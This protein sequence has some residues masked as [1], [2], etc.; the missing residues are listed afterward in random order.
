GQTS[1]VES[2]STGILVATAATAGLLLPFFQFDVLTAV[3]SLGSSAFAG[4]T[5]Y[6]ALQP[7]ASI[8]NGGFLAAA[9]AIAAVGIQIVLSYRGRL[10]LEDQVRPLY[11]RHLAER[12]K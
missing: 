3:V 7:V 4:S 1:I 6:L 2:W 11:A 8:R 10:Y 5:T 9:I 12:L